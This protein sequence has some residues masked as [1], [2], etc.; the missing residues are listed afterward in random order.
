LP[1]LLNP[2]LYRLHS[3]ATQRGRGGVLFQKGIESAICTR[4]LYP[5]RIT[6]KTL[7]TARSEQIGRILRNTCIMWGVLAFITLAFMKITGWTP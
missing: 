2:T 3:L 5:R 7:T 6:M 1:A 4:Y